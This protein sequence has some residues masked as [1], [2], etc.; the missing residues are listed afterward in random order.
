MFGIAG[1]FNSVFTKIF[2]IICIP[3]LKLNP[4]WAM[5]FISFVAGIMMLWIFGKVSNQDAIKKVK[6][7]IKGNM[8]GVR[9]YGN[10]IGVVLKLQGIILKDTLI[11]MKYSVIPMLVM[12]IPVI[13][14]IIQLNLRFS[15]AP[16]E[17]GQS[18]IVNVKLRDISEVPVLEVPDGVVMETSG[19]FIPSENEVSWRIRAD[20][21]GNYNLTIK[22]NSESISKELIA[23]SGWGDIS[24]LKTGKDI[25]EV[26]LF[27][28]EKPINSNSPIESIEIKYK[29][30]KTPVFGFNIH[31]LVHFFILSIVFGFAF[32]GVFGI[33]I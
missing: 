33:Q 29:E 6:N 4:I 8:I 13:L 24:A 16:L 15:V 22:T 5:I 18:I 31:W 26:F 10:D 11:Y 25:W 30:L 23:G 12:M 32:K 20:K 14:I 27:P 28:G 1:I 19:I 17:P 2:D 21:P 3:F 9:L 7:K